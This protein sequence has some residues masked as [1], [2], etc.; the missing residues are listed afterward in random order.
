MQSGSP[1][2]NLVLV[3]SNQ[4]DLF[5]MYSAVKIV[6]QMAAYLRRL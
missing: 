3:K 1:W 2:K 6:P 5:I 4:T